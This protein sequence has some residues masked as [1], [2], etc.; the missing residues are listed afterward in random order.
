MPKILY[1]Y[2]H[3]TIYIPYILYI[4]TYTIFAAVYVH[5]I[6]AYQENNLFLL[7]I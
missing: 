2:I 1:N 3:K 7:Y 5:R 6:D 4:Y